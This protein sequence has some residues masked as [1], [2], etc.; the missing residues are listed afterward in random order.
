M[1]RDVEA[2]YMMQLGFGMKGSNYYIFTGGPNPLNFGTTSDSYDY[3]AAVASDG[4][5]RPLYE[6]E[7]RIGG[8]L[9]E[10][11]WLYNSERVHDCRIAYDLK[12][13]RSDEYWKNKTGFLVT[14]PELYKFSQKGML[15]TLF[16]GSYSPELCD[17]DSGNWMEDTG[18]P[19]IVLSSSCMTAASQQRV[20]DFLKK[21]GKVILCPVIPEYD[22]NFEPC[23]ILKE[24]LGSSRLEINTKTNQRISFKT[25][26]NVMSNEV[27]YVT[28]QPPA[29]ASIIGEDENNNLPVAWKI[30]TENNGSLIFLGIKWL[31]QMREHIRMM[32]EVLTDLGINKV[33]RCSNQNLFTS[34]RTNGEKSM[35]FVMNLYSSPMQGNI[36]VYSRD[37]KNMIKNISVDLEPMKVQTID[38]ENY[39]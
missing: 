33:I 38:I 16:C 18:N 3:N 36:E 20:A 10:N 29:K 31:H 24:F 13:A 27:N 22:E 21:G 32:D 34:L 11:T 14:N 15:N 25:V 39:K 7:K 8:F 26:K 4:A 2:A 17:L 1:P 19:L 5:I 9:K 30:E 12:I 35:L 6:T 28:I 23:T 37:G